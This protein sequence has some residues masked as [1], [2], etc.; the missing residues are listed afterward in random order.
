METIHPLTALILKLHDAFFPLKSIYYMFSFKSWPKQL[1]IDLGETTPCQLPC[2][3]RL[4]EP[5]KADLLLKRL[6]HVQ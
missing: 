5:L 6:S 2:S 1:G 3:G 4:N